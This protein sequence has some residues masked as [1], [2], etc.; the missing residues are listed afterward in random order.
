MI[1]NDMY[2]LILVFTFI[3]ENINM[4]LYKQNKWQELDLIHTS[5]SVFCIKQNI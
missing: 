4:I 3:L 1:T 5:M 2:K